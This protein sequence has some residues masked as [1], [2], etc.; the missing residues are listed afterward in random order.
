MEM[1]IDAVQD[2][3]TAEKHITRI[4]SGLED[5][6][7]AELVRDIFGWGIPRLI[8]KIMKKRRDSFRWP[9]EVEALCAPDAR[10]KG[11]LDI[12]DTE[13]VKAVRNVNVNQTWSG[14]FEERVLVR[15]RY[16]DQQQGISAP[17]REVDS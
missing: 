9:E 1:G 12:Y 2:Y 13:P 3:D 14:V 15:D 17:L 5:K 10:E 6:G 4:E 8:D 11:L 7:K 16:L